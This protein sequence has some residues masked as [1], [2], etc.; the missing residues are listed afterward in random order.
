MPAYFILVFLFGLIIGSFLNCFIWRLHKKIP[1]TPFVKGGDKWKRSY[2][3][4]CGKQIAWH[5]NVPILSFILLAGKCR[6]CKK[7]ISWQ[8]PAVELATGLLFAAAYYFNQELTVRLARDWFL[9]SAMIVI[10]IYDL[11]WYLILD[12]IT[13]PACLVMLIFNLILGFDLWNLLI[14]GI[15]GGSFFLIQ[16]VISKGKWIGGGDIRLG[17]LIG[18][19]FG[20][21]GVL[22]AIIIS[23]FI[24]SIIGISLVLAR[25][26]EFGSQMPLG[27]FLAAGAIIILFWQDNILN[28]YWNLF[29]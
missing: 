22:A 13:L 3:P 4:K 7:P 25:K 19:S 21:P 26:K 23:Y 27:V 2:C 16:F 8:Y 1:L 29:L 28:W 5:D 14:S 20:W 9:I 6:H 11:R 17:L 10:F 24:G 12:I 15:I 18:L